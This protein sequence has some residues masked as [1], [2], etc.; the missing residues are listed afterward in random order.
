[1]SIKY[2]GGY[3]PAVG[4][5]GTTLVANSSASTGVSW[6]GNQAGGKNYLINGAMEFF[7]RGS[8]SAAG[9]AL[10]R[11]KTTSY[12]TSW[13]SISFTQGTTTPPEGFR[14]YMRVAAGS[15]TN[16]NFGF[17]Q[18]LETTDVVKF[19]NKTVT[20]S[21]YY[22][23]NTNFSSAWTVT[24]VYSIGTDADISNVPNGTAIGSNQTITNTTSWNRFTYSFTVPSTATSFAVQFFNS[25]NTVSTASLDI[26]GVQLEIGSVATPFSRAGGTLQ[27]ELAACQRYY[28]RLNG[29]DV[30]GSTI[31]N[32]CNGYVESSTVITGI[33]NFPI[34]MRIPPSIAGGASTNFI[35]LG[36]G[37]F[38]YPATLSTQAISKINAR[39]SLTQTSLTAYQAGALLMSYNAT[40]YLE[41]SAEL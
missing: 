11:W 4:A 40:D 26:T 30:S 36:G 41:H 3:I 33:Y 32:I 31:A 2:N 6:Q 25:N 37:S 23:V 34:Q 27:G 19:A 5:D 28:W 22:I 15:S 20:L 38:H 18:A 16:T 7:Q 17:G 29:S 14:Y 24:P 13:N 8:I 35:A 12:G 21:F 39:I 9:Y 10:D 1:M